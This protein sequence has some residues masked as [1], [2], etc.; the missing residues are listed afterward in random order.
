MYHKIDGTKRYDAED[1]DLVMPMY[2]LI[3]CSSNNSETTGSL[4]IYSKDEATD[5]NA[6]IAN[7][8][9]FESFMYEAKVLENS[10]VDG[11]NG[12]LKNA[13]IAVTLKFEIS[14]E[15]PLINWTKYCVLFPAGE[16]NVN[17]RDSDNIIFTIKGTKLYVLV[18]TL[19]ARDNQKVS[20]TF[21]KGFQRSV[22]WN[23]Y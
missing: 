9:N 16:D 3:E 7:I 18:V 12:I 6:D 14:F 20:K 15:M 21:S 4:Q 17:N 13:T 19:S 10:E 22:Y 11:A 8:N 23:E 1:I 2:N 5:F